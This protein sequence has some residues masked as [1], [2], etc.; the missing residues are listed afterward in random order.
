[1]VDPKR[2]KD[3]LDVKHKLIFK[4]VN[5]LNRFNIYLVIP[6]LRVICNPSCGSGSIDDFL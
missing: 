1:M 2:Q 5:K 3:V 6:D 4:R